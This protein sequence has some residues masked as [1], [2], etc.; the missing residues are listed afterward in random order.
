[1]GENSLLAKLG[2]AFLFQAPAVC[3]E[4]HQTYSTQT[5]WLR[6]DQ[7]EL[8]NM[9]VRDLQKHGYILTGKIAEG[10]FILSYKDRYT[11][12]LTPV[13]QKTIEINQHCL[14]QNPQYLEE[15]K[16]YYTTQLYPRVDNVDADATLYREDFFNGFQKDRHICTEFHNATGRDKAVVIERFSDSRLRELAVHIVF[17]HFPENMP[18]HYVQEMQEYLQ[19]I[20]NGQASKMRVDYNGKEFRPTRGDLLKQVHEIRSDASH[21]LTLEELALL[22]ELESMAIPRLNEKSIRVFEEN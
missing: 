14:A 16:D 8:S 17:W 20:Y 5:K 2:G 21:S 10:G 15:I 11:R 18:E 6:L 22:N 13:R 19:G 4:Y 9:Q 3:L 1:M 12:Y 7:A